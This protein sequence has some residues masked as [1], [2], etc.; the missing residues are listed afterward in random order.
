[1]SPGRVAFVK[2]SP[3]ADCAKARCERTPPRRPMATRMTSG[4]PSCASHK[5]RRL[6]KDSGSAGGN[7]RFRDGNNGGMDG[8]TGEFGGSEGG[9][10]CGGPG[11]KLGGGGG[12]GGGGWMISSTYHLLLSTLI[13][14]SAP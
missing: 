2:E 8:G 14:K 9:G 13:S 10:I 6:P 3:A 7:L 5:R 1:M 12:I 11:G 4:S